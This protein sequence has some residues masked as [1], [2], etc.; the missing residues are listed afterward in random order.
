MTEQTG[1]PSGQ[2]KKLFRLKNN[3]IVGGVCAG[4]AEYLNIDATIVRIVW[5]LLVIWGGVGILAYIAGLI[6]IP[7]N[8]DEE[9]VERAESSSS[10]NSAIIWGVLLILFGLFFLSSEFDFWNFHRIFFWPRF[11][12]WHVFWPVLI[13]F[14]G[15]IYIVYVLRKDSESGKQPEMPKEWVVGGKRL[16]R[17]TSGKMIAG[18]CAG[19]AEYL[20]IDVAFVRLGW[21][22]FTIFASWFSIITYV[23][24]AIALPTEEA[25]TPSSDATATPVPPESSEN[26]TSETEEK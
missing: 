14:A 1:A 17:V 9:V 11:F 5:V 7:E 23:V 24:L 20:N 15:I 18:V 19:V 22:V 2:P 21:V 3:R 16:Y 12:H 25:A 10:G 26:T 6:L 13:I 4:F 8:P